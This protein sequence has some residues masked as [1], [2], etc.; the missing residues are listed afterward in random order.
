MAEPVLLR[1]AKA[2]YR[3]DTLTS[4]SDW[5]SLDKAEQRRYENLAAAAL[6]VILREPISDIELSLSSSN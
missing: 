6:S 4:K 3:A 1:T 2:M 5:G